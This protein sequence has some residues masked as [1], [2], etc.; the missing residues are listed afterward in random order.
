MTPSP[1]PRSPVKL[2]APVP[3]Q[4][5]AFLI[6]RSSMRSPFSQRVGGSQLAYP[7]QYLG[8]EQLDRAQDLLARDRQEVQVEDSRVQLCPDRPDL[9]QYRVRAAHQ[10]LTELYALLQVAC[11]ESAAL[12]R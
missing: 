9:R 2:G 7:G 11:L 10:Q 4:I 12:R 5:R 1:T 6:S 8:T 3:S